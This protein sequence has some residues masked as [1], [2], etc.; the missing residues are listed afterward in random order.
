MFLKLVTPATELPL[1]LDEV[2]AHLRMDGTDEDDYITLLLKSAVQ[3]AQNFT[4]RQIMPATFQLYLDRLPSSVPLPRPPFAEITSFKATDDAGQ[5]VVFEETDYTLTETEH[6]TIRGIA[7]SGWYASCYSDIK[8]TYKAGYA[9]ADAVPEDIKSALLLM[10]GSMYENREDKTE[11]FPKASE[12]M[13][14]PYRVINI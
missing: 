12:S 13:L 11:R 3:Q 7:D 9:T 5:E 14:T 8:I 2:K 1:T 4:N 6:T 10:I